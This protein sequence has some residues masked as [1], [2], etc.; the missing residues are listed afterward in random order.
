MDNKLESGDSKLTDTTLIE[1][2]CNSGKNP[3]V[4]YFMIEK[5]KLLTT[6]LIDCK[7]N[8][9]EI[10]KSSEFISRNL[11]KISK[12][13]IKMDDDELKYLGYEDTDLLNDDMIFIFKTLLYAFKIYKDESDFDDG[14]IFHCTG[15]FR[16]GLDRKYTL[17]EFRG[18]KEVYERFTY[19]IY[20]EDGNTI[21][22][23]DNYW[24]VY[25]NYK[26]ETEMFN[27]Y[28]DI[29]SII[30]KINKN[31]AIQFQYYL[32]KSY[33]M[34]D[35]RIYHT[36]NSRHAVAALSDVDQKEIN[37]FC[38]NHKIL[39][40]TPEKRIYMANNYKMISCFVEFRKQCPEIININ[41]KKLL[42]CEVS[43]LIGNLN[44]FDVLVLSITYNRIEV[45]R[46]IDKKPIHYE[47]VCDTESDDKME[48]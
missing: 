40:D 9:I 18:D 1:I 27:F 16:G 24:V 39:L 6:I 15:S 12:P 38:D 10:N 42:K 36:Y 3:V 29:C 35:L 46:I 22:A 23:K 21:R 5:F 19:D 25:D 31:Y 43:E 45:G 20:D 37:A 11:H 44:S 32:K 33:K 28:N 34:F 17:H 7:E 13:G 26:R 8:C 4:P 30:L 41:N 2:K 48:L 14:H 47:F